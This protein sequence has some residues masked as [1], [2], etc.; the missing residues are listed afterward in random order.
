MAN[1]YTQLHI[2][3]VCV[4]K[5]REALIHQDWKTNL[6]KYIAGIIQN[7][8]HKLLAIN[9]VEDHIHLFIGM[10]PTE[11]VSDFM[12]DIKQFSSKW[13]NE[14]KFVKRKFE[15]QEGFGAF[16]YSLDA[17]PNVVNY[18]HNQELHHSKTTFNDEYLAF[19]NEF[20]ID[21]DEKYLFKLPA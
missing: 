5:Y 20:K 14:N 11:A 3:F 1:T 9:G 8:G 15:W 4:V 12:K 21:Y 19:L 10:R 2:Q 7:K 18:I 13:I 6:F 16:S 17:V